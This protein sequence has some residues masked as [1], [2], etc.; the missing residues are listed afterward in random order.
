MRTYKVVWKVHY[1]LEFEIDAEGEEEA[2]TKLFDRLSTPYKLPDGWY[3]VSPVHR[4]PYKTMMGKEDTDRHPE[5]G[6]G[7]HWKTC[8]IGNSNG[9]QVV[10][11]EEKRDESK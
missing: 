9:F 11:A 10:S 7:Q 5:F 6:Y 2:K 4:Y 8:P 1:D 3:D